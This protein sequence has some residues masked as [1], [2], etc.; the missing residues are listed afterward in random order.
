MGVWRM[1]SVTRFGAD[2]VEF[3]ADAPLFAWGISLVVAGMCLLV[4]QGMWVAEVQ[5]R[6]LVHGYPDS[7]VAWNFAAYCVREEN[8]YEIVVPLG[9][10]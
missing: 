4:G 5:R 1:G 2:V 3:F 8:E 7:Y 10:L 6:C 9:D